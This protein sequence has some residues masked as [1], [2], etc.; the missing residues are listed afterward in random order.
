[1]GAII[2]RLGDQLFPHLSGLPDDAPIFMREDAGLARAARHHRQKLTLFFA[3]MRHHA[4][5]LTAMGRWVE[6]QR[7]L[8]EDPG[9][10]AAVVA[11]ARPVVW[12][13]SGH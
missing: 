2:L 7:A 8:R 9:Y 4:A 1:M 6:Y 10:G 11:Y 13:G 5:E 12:G 3:A